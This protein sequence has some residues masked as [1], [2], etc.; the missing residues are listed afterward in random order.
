MYIRGEGAALVPFIEEVM[1]MTKEELNK[2]GGEDGKPDYGM[3]V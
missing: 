3:V 1:G 2:Q